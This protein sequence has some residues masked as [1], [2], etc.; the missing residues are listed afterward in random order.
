M[1]SMRRGK[2]YGKILRLRMACILFSALAFYWKNFRKFFQ[3]TDWRSEPT[4]GIVL[5]NLIGGAM[6]STVYLRVALRAED[7]GW[8]RHQSVKTINGNNNVMVVDFSRNA[9]GY[10]TA[11]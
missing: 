3:W 10:A 1:H 7:D 6:D 5:W 11:A 2:F 9:V 4:A 8:L